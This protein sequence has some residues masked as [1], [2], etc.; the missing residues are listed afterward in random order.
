MDDN[1]KK[2]APLGLVISG[3]AL[4]TL[5]GF[6]ITNALAECASWPCPTTE[7]L[8]TRGLWISVAT[9]LLGLAVTALL[10]PEGVR[11]FFHRTAGALRQQFA[12]SFA[13]GH[14]R[15]ILCQCAG[16]RKPPNLG[17]DRRQAE[18]ADA[19]DHLPSSNRS[20]PRFMPRLLQHPALRRKAQPG[21]WKISNLTARANSLMN[22]STLNSTRCWPNKTKSNATGRLCC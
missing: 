3:L 10:D 14:R 6:L 12:D 1:N 11:K 4:L 21:C 17:Y 22:L 7:F 20:K 15:P 19:R 5:I 2:Y 9:I 8:I 13:G 16:F 18:Y